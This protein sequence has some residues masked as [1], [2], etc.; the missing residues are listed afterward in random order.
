MKRHF[1]W[2]QEAKCRV[3]G[4]DTNL[5][6]PSE[7]QGKDFFATARAICNE[8]TV[9]ADC[10]EYALSFPAVEDIAGM[11]GGL[12]PWQRETIRQVV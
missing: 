9:K 6:F 8:C 4:Y 2:M 1:K 10:L 12:S 7:P 3:D 11:Y 5:W